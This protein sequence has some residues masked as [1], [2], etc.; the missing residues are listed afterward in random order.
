MNIKTYDLPD[1]VLM[2]DDSAYRCM[3][4]QPGFLAIILG[5]S[6]KAMDSLYMD[7]VIQDNVPV[8]KRPSGGETVILS[9]KT[10]VISIAKRGDQ[11]KSPTKYFRAYNEQI[12]AA[13][14]NLG[15]QNLRSD[16][17]SDICIG[18]KKILG[19]S[20][21]RNKDLVLYHAVLNIGEKVDTIQFYLKHPLKEPDYR[22]GRSH[23][24]F[25]TSINAMGYHIPLPKLRESLS[26]YLKEILWT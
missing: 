2:E 15:I 4:W 20:I 26:F 24:D 19:S 8:Y 16:G 17:I 21:Y 1:A 23:K 25:V 3:I 6:N 7:R 12:I 11:L 22:K 5:Q 10:L 14:T 18:E 9:P 13:L